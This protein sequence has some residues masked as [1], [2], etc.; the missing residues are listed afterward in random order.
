M[1][2]IGRAASR[3]PDGS[4]YVTDDVGGRIWKINYSGN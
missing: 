3:R 4:L 1:R 2:R